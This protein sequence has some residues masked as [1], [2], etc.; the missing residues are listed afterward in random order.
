VQDPV[1]VMRVGFSEPLDPGDWTE[2]E[3][4]SLVILRAEGVTIEP[5]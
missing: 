3:D 5:L 1:S 4:H 2:V